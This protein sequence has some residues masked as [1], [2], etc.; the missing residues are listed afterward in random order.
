MYCI[1]YRRVEG[2]EDE[3]ERGRDESWQQEQDWVQEKCKQYKEQSVN[4]MAMEDKMLSGQMK[5]F[6]N[7][8]SVSCSCC[9]K[10]KN[11]IWFMEPA[12]DMLETR[13]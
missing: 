1:Y 6:H 10:G 8:Q 11:S 13:M 3:M 9:W 2:R 4:Y 7:V 5:R 12:R